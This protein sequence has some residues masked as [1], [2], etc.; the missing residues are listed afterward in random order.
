[1]EKILQATLLYDFYGELLTDKQKLIFDMYYLNDLSLTEIGQELN[2][3]RQAVRDQINRTEKVLTE[4]E[5]KLKLVEKFIIQQNSVKKMKLLI[6]DIENQFD[7]KQEIVF[8]IEE[9]KKIA[10]EIL[11]C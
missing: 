3:S 6:E 9:I 7:L 8:N 1:M 5:Y 11:E 2:I 10:E 4:Y